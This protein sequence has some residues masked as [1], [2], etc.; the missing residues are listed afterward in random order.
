MIKKMIMNPSESST[1]GRRRHSRENG[2]RAT[3]SRR[4]FTKEQNAELDALARLP[5]DQINVSDAPESE[6]GAEWHFFKDR[7][8]FLE[9]G[10]RRKSA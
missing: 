1:L 3:N 10:K 5:D 7:H 6:P 4:R 9:K 2:T 8:R